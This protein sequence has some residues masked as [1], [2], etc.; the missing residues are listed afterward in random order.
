MQKRHVLTV[1]AAL[2]LSYGQASQPAVTG[3]RPETCEIGDIEGIRCGFLRVA[4]N[5]ADPSRRLIAIH[6]MVAPATGPDPLPDPV[7]LFYGGPG[8]A[9]SDE[10]ARDAERW[11]S[12]RERRDLVFID[13]R[14]TG[15][16]APLHCAFA[17]DPDD[18]DTYAIGLF[19]LEHL[20]ACRARHDATADLVHY[21]TADA[22]R[23]VEAVRT[24]LGYETINA[25]GESYGTRVVQ[26]YIRR[27]PGRVRAALLLGAVP[28]SASIT[29]GM[30]ESLDATL[31][32]LF[33]S[34]ESDRACAAA[35][36]HLRVEIEGFLRRAQAEDVRAVIRLDEGQPREIALPYDLVIAWVRSRLYSVTESARLPLALTQ[37]ARGD[38]RALALGAV[39]WRR[40]VSR[41]LSE[42]MYASVTCSEDMPFINL[43]AE[44]S[45]A[46][47]T[48]LGDRRVVGQQ[49]ACAIWPR[50]AIA[51]DVKTPV[52]APTPILVINGDRDPATGLD[53]A[54]VI[55]EHAP[56]ARLV[57]AR[58]RSHALRSELHDCLAAIARQF[59]ETADIASVDDGCAARLELPPFETGDQAS[60]TTAPAP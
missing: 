30:A 5:R 33:A 44:T 9:A 49:A 12:T 16:S 39:R 36:P 37:A 6:V 56:N 28:P 10:A 38:A 24:A 8:A 52:T 41:L 13:Q 4:E 20:A 59:I 7:F 11:R 42:G 54:R 48:W 40:G 22:V 50:I 51:G 25:I 26:E 3:I 18:P 43:E 47:G 14:G 45:A 27:Y 60:P 57:V 31:D 53:W 23:D 15:R 58:N 29:E 34:C 1:V 21:G 32:Q 55:V 2:G 17:G 19:D 35:Y 46:K